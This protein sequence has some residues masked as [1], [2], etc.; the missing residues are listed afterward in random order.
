VETRKFA[1]QDIQVGLLGAGHWALGTGHWAAALCAVVWCGG[2]LVW[3]RQ[4]GTSRGGGQ[5]A[6]RASV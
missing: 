3:L 1:G 4:V 6:C 2:D 5:Q